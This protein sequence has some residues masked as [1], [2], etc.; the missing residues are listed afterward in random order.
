MHLAA[1][2]LL[3]LL[4][5]FG[6][7][8]IPDGQGRTA[9]ARRKL[10]PVGAELRLGG[11]LV[12]VRQIAQEKE[13]QHVV[14]EVIGVHRPAQLV[15]DGPEGLAQ[16]RLLLLGHAVVSCASAAGNSSGLKR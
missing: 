11:F 3:K 16:L 2:H 9:I 5:I 10:G 7:L 4:G 15:G 12:I 14:A 8:R 13:R 1:H 6:V